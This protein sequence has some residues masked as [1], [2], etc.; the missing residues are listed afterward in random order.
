M[1]SVQP[2]SS[3]TIPSSG[4]PCLD[5]FHRSVGRPTTCY[6]LN[7]EGKR[8]YSP[9]PR[10]KLLQISIP[11][12]RVP[13]NPSTCKGSASNIQVRDHWR[14]L[15]RLTCIYSVRCRRGT[16]CKLHHRRR[17]RLCMACRIG[18]VVIPFIHGDPLGNLIQYGASDEHRGL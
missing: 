6:P 4:P 18:R 9:Q 12:Q 8:Y 15:F 3:A 11:A 1:P 2:H 17:N 14:W 7:S 13:P 10:V 5:S 16:C